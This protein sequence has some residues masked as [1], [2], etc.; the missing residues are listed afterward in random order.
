MFM[1]RR[2][3]GVFDLRTGEETIATPGVI[4]RFWCSFYPV[5]DVRGYGVGELK[6]IKVSY[7]SDHFISKCIL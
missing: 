4:R 2:L 3:S 7:I 1:R 5:E 6:Y